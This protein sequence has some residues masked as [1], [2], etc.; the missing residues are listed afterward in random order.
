MPPS[1]LLDLASTIIGAFN[2]LILCVICSLLPTIVRD[3]MSWT[4]DEVDQ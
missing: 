1:I 3:I 4:D 2:L